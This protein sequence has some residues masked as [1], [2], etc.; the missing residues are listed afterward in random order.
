MQ[1]EL[2]KKQQLLFF[3]DRG[4][5]LYTACREAGVNLRAGSIIERHFKKTKRVE[6]NVCNEEFDKC[7][8]FATCQKC[9]TLLDNLTPDIRT[10]TVTV[11]RNYCARCEIGMKN[12]QALICQTCVN[13]L[14]K[15]E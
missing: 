9:K 7:T 4:V 14:A 15:E 6:C 2:Y 1:T 3:L 11:H 5:D 10:K 13:E 8:A 12:T